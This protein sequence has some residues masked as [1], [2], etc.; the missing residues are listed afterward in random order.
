MK[1]KDFLTKP[2][3]GLNNMYWASVPNITRNTLIMFVDTKKMYFLSILDSDE[4][5]LVI[6]HSKCYGSWWPGDARSQ[7][8]SNDYDPIIT[9][10]SSCN[11]TRV[12]FYVNERM[13]RSV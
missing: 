6:L 3:F 4:D 1:L 2:G 7:C 5:R 10:Y 11:T 12:N 13:R 9:E 8:I